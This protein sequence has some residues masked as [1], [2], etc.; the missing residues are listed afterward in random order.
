M[1]HGLLQEA[2][3]RARDRARR[4][5]ERGLESGDPEL[6]RVIAFGADRARRQER[7]LGRIARGER[8]GRSSAAP[9]TVLER[10]DVTPDLV[11]FRIARPPTL[12]FEPGQ[13]VHVGLGGVRR[14]YSIASRPADPHLELTIERVPGGRLTPELWQVGRGELL[15]IGDRAKGKLTLASA[16]AHVMF[17]TVTGVAPFA[18]MIRDA[19]P[20]ARGRFVL[21]HG[22]RH[23]AELILGDDLATLAEAHPDRFTYL[24]SVTQP[25]AGWAGRTG[26][27]TEHVDE[28]LS[29]IAES[30]RPHGY[31]CGHPQMVEDMAALLAGRGLPVS[32]EAYF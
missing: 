24:P 20:R 8:P 16:D 11:V 18:S 22:A 25:G 30:R 27:V 4:R 17:A 23:P 14:K 15:E 2:S 1:T 6:A 21:V 13:Y 3:G 26:R 31:A 7:R 28:A 19:V 9:G 5:V 12:S 10:V 32:T 29:L